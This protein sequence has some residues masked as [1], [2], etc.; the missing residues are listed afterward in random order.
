[1]LKALDIYYIML[2]YIR[3]R[4][5]RLMSSKFYWT[6]KCSDYWNL[7]FFWEKNYVFRHSFHG[8]RN[9]SFFA[10]AHTYCSFT[11]TSGKTISNLHIRVVQFHATAYPESVEWIINIDVHWNAVLIGLHERR[12]QTERF[13]RLSE[14]E[15]KRNA[16]SIRRYCGKELIKFNEFEQP[17]GICRRADIAAPDFD[18]VGVSTGIPM[19]RHTSAR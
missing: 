15:K 19:L 10:L 14:G 7:V 18:F 1:M 9:N 11:Q 12:N 2:Y 6:A 3:T 13:Y 4:W 5:K 17:R 16:N 8:T